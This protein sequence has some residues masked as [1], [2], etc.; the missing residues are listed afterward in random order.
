MRG[1]VENL[2]RRAAEKERLF[3]AAIKQS[4]EIRKQRGF[5]ERKLTKRA[6]DDLASYQEDPEKLAQELSK[7]LSKIESD[8][9]LA[10]FI[11]SAERRDLKMFQAIFGNTTGN[12]V[13]LFQPVID[14][15]VN[16]ICMVEDAMHTHKWQC[17]E[18]LL[19]IMKV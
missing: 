10:C 5:K 17:P 6:E 8:E 16:T 18:F 12:E 2:G 15:Q 4:I 14:Y 9:L 1:L 3:E 11:L 13:G 7:H 19:G